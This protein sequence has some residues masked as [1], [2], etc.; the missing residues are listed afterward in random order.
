[1]AT[2]PENKIDSNSTG[3]AM[4]EEACIGKLPDAVP[5]S[6]D[7]GGAVWYD[8]EP[9]NYADFGGTVQTVARQP[10]DPAR[11]NKKGTVVTVDAAAGLSQDVTRSNFLRAM[12]GF[13]FANARE[14]AKTQPL[15]GTQAPI[16]GVTAANKQYAAT[17]GLLP[18]NRAG[19]LILVEG[20]GSLSNNGLKTVV[21]ATA[22]AITVSENI[23]NEAAPPAAAKITL[24]G[25]QFPADDVS[26]AVT[27]GIP[28]LVSTA[29]NLNTLG[30]TI[31]EWVHLGG[32]VLATQLGDNVG[33]ARIATIAAGAITF[34]D[35]TFTPVTQS[36]AGKTTRIYFGTVIRNE[37]DP[38]LIK[39]KSYQFER[40]LGVTAAG[41]TQAEYVKGAVANQFTLN[42]PNSDKL[43][44]DITYVAIDSEMRNGTV[45]QPRKG[46]V[47][48]AALGEDAINTSSDLFRFKVAI[49]DPA[50]SAP[51]PLF[52][53]ATESN[54]AIDNGVTVL[55]ALG[56]I[57]GFD[58][59]SGNFGVTGSVTAFFS[60]VDAVAAVRNN[61]DVGLSMIF[62]AKNAGQVYDL[63]LVSLGNGRPQVELNQSIMLPLDTNAAENAKGYTMLYVNF[64]YLPNVA[65]S[66]N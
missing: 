34:D 45:D 61:A 41:N 7:E 36:G 32:D 25:Y 49:V 39:R 19:N 26:I 13:M 54:I 60:T 28:S 29:A 43:T 22:G 23:V 16:T 8:M 53:Y 40:T 55:K 20:F 27:A 21:S 9:N 3:L 64:H 47:H 62:A 30:L 59:S 58:T 17:T 66:K 48:V 24:V 52:G 15:N 56:R 65:M 18:F 38:S 5:D 50:T 33:Y 37:K 6:G 46:G 51:T 42:V 1:M 10:L 2:C 63:P 4:A 11:Q 14:K 31:G 57:G 35:T 12:Q 44:A